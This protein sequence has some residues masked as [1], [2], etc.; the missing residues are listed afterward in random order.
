MDRTGIYL[1]ATFLFLLMAVCTGCLDGRMLNCKDDE[2]TIVNHCDRKSL[3][4][5]TGSTKI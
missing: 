5:M 1:H 3:L 4:F 2:I